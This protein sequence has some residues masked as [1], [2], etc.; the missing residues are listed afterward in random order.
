MEREG[1]ER[2]ERE[3]KGGKERERR[4]REK[5]NHIDKFYIIPRIY[6]ADVFLR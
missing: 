5:E 4:E 1:G 3:R 2:E 6:R